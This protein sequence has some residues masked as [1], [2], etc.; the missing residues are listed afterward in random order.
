MK[1]RSFKPIN[2]MCLG[3]M[4][5]LFLL[6]IL[7]YTDD[8]IEPATPDIEIFTGGGI[9]QWTQTNP[10]MKKLS[11]T[12]F[13]ED[14]QLSGPFIQ[15]LS[16][17]NKMEQQ[18]GIQWDPKIME[19]LLNSPMEISLWNAFERDKTTTFV[20]VMDIKPQFQALV[21]LAEFYVKTQKKSKTVGN[22]LETQW[23]EQTLY[24]LVRNNQLLIANSLPPL[25]RILE[26]TPRDKPVKP[27]R[28]S[29]FFK[30]FCQ[31]YNGNFKCRVN[32]AAWLTNLEG[33]MDKDRMDLAANID[34][35][36]TVV[37]HSFFL[38]ADPGFQSSEHCSLADCK[39]VIPKE[40]VLAAAGLYASPYYLGLIKRLPGFKDLQKEY[41]INVE[42]DVFPFFNER[43][44]FYVTGFQKNDSEN[45]LDGVIGF[46]L[47]K[48]NPKEKKA[49]ISF[50][51]LVITPG[52]EEMETEKYTDN[53][54]I[55]RYS[56]PNEPVFCL[57]DHW[58][59]VG[60]GIEPLE[61]SLAV[62]TKK[63][64]SM[65]D[66]TA[67]R[68]M[69]PELSKKGFGHVLFSPPRFFD[70]LGAHL[71]FLAKSVKEFNSVDVTYKIL[72][73][74]KILS[75][76]PPFALRLD[77]QEETLKGKIEFCEKME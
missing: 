19:E 64:P 40:T 43:F 46:S 15:L 62:Y 26:K 66:G 21:K 18:L 29:P 28:N 22:V 59:L 5:L 8:T 73:A 61:E 11:T 9:Y 4:A 1:I 44:F 72:P 38:S 75:E 48:Y 68:A 49:I 17:A 23:M 50:V 10:Y 14:L 41:K 67:Y 20:F 31:P 32:L 53:I 57:L 24:H 25:S 74:F 71:L 16:A 42:K 3:M 58:L 69:E 12:Q 45:I 52:G 30:T 37:Y 36:E 35:G 56:Q 63:K 47:N 54:D 65:A 39:E 13:R 55:Y 60:T 27:F 77:A 51:K 70:S 33:L 6:P 7:S 2:G 76:I 34:L